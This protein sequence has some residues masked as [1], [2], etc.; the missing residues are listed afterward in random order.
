MSTTKSNHIINIE[1]LNDALLFHG[2][3]VFA[4]S[5]F[6]TEDDGASGNYFCKVRHDET[7]IVTQL[8]YDQNLKFHTIEEVTVSTVDTNHT[9]TTNRFDPHNF[10]QDL[11]VIVNDANAEL[12]K[13]TERYVSIEYIAAVLAEDVI[14]EAYNLYHS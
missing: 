12:R 13:Y 5:T 4:D 10:S 3:K 6:T 1:L 2:Y 9:I 11:E 7:T 14:V 8:K